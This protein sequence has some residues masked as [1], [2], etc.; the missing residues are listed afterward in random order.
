MAGCEL[1]PIATARSGAALSVKVFPWGMSF[2]PSSFDCRRSSL[3]FWSGANVCWSQTRAFSRLLA[4]SFYRWREG[5]LPNTVIYAM[6]IPRDS[7]E[8]SHLLFG[9]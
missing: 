5:I 7:N 2:V 4:L 8:R 9:F 1:E 3:L 6:S